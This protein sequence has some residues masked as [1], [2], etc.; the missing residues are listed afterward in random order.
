MVPSV[1]RC[2][3]CIFAV[4][5][6]STAFSGLICQNRQHDGGCGVTLGENRA[7]QEEDVPI[8]ALG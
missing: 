2:F 3:D 7:Q 1:R 4:A 5:D 8:T 6:E